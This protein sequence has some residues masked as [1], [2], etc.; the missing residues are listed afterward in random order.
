MFL[1]LNDGYLQQCGLALSDLDPR[2]P[3]DPDSVPP[4]VLINC[5]FVLVLWLIQHF[6]Y[7]SVYV[8]PPFFVT[9]SFPTFNMFLRR[10]TCL[11]L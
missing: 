3:Y 11:V 8:H 9:G 7:I 6:L 4:T 2:K 1:F 5:V 10:V